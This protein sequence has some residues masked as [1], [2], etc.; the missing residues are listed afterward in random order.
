MKYRFDIGRGKSVVFSAKG[1]RCVDIGEGELMVN[2]D[3]RLADGTTIDA[4][5]V[6]D[7][8]SSGEHCGTYF[9]TNDAI[10]WQGD[11]GF[12]KAIGKTKEQVFPYKYRPR[13]AIPGDIHTDTDGW[14]R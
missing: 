10:V 5:L 1:K 7:A 12:L 2:A 9:L 14:S 13:V 4:V 6:I 3:V 8:L 11:V